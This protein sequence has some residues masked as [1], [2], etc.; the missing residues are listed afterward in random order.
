[1]VIGV[2]IDYTIHFLNKYRSK[3]QEGLIDP[4]AI[5]LATMA[6]SG[7]AIFFNAIVVMG[8]FAVLLASNFLPNWHLGAMMVLNM[9]ACLVSSMTILPMVLNILYR[10]FCMAKKERHV[11]QPKNLRS[12]NTGLGV[13]SAESPGAQHRGESSSFVVWGKLPH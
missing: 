4:E 2:G 7:K 11:Q 3:V 5:T 6:T 12:T 13:R 10:V 9:E 1:M 8:G